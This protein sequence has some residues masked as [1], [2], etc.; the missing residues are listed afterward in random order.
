MIGSIF[1]HCSH[2]S[3]MVIQEK[4]SLENGIK[5][6][7]EAVTNIHTWPVLERYEY[8]SFPFL[9]TWNSQTYSLFNTFSF[10]GAVLGAVISKSGAN[11]VK[12]I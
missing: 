6:A 9:A 10:I 3:K 7:S 4:E 8:C 1:M 12:M 5:S 2:T 11:V